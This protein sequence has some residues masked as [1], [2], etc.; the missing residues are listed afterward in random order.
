VLTPLG[1]WVVDLF[2]KGG[3]SVNSTPVRSAR[4]EDGDCLQVG[5]FVIRARY[6]QPAPARIPFS[7]LADATGPILELQGS[8]V[9]LPA[10]Q[11]TFSH[12]AL[13]QTQPVSSFPVTPGTEPALAN[14][15]SREVL[16]L[17]TE[18]ANYV[19]PAAERARPAPATSGPR[20]A[21]TGVAANHA[22]R[23][24]LTAKDGAQ[25][26]PLPL[27]QGQPEKD[28]HAWLS[29]RLAALQ[30]ERQTRWQKIVNYLTGNANE[31]STP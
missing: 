14:E 16:A 5:N 20:A 22:S 8:S 2:G 11:E 10:L 24:A 21:A 4:L 28:M 26:K 13:G 3:I 25:T 9:S 19:Q 15:L 17:Q 7:H 18:L 6:L 23:P 27:P 29:Q 31:K 12:Q 30:Q 1:L